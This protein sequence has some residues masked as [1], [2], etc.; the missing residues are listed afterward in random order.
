MTNKFINDTLDITNFSI[1][2]FVEKFPKFTPVIYGI[3]HVT[4][5]KWY[6]G[7]TNRLCYRIFDHFHGFNHSNKHFQDVLTKD[8]IRAFRVYLLQVIEESQDIVQ[9]E[10]NWIIK[11]NS[12]YPNG[13]NI[14]LNIKESYSKTPGYFD[15]CQA[16]PILEILTGRMF[17]SISHC[18]EVLDIPASAIKSP[19]NEYFKKVSK[20]DYEQYIDNGGIIYA[21]PYSRNSRLTA[22]RNTSPHYS[23]LLDGREVSRF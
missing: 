20:G 3:L 11:L 9:I 16:S 6:V 1:S 18:S 22:V 12:L 13:F 23:I 17:N 8:G 19:H 4:T 14:K 2:E 5:G 10:D 21:V 15:H 7:Q